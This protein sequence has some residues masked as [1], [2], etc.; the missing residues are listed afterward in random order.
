[1]N[2]KAILFDLVGLLV[3]SEPLW[4]EAKRRTFAPLGI[5]LTASMQS[6][7]TGMRQHDMVDYWYR[8]SP[9][10]GPTVSTVARTVI[11][12]MRN[13]IDEEGVVLM[14]GA[15]EAL[16]FTRGAGFV[17]AVVSSS[18]FE[19]I[20][21]V[22]IKADL[23][24]AVPSFFSAED[25]EHGKPHPAVY[26]R[27]AG[28]LGVDPQ[29]CVAVE[30]SVHGVISGKAATMSVVAVPLSAE[31]EDRRFGVADRVISSLHSLPKAV[32]GLQ[33]N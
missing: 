23:L 11:A 8:A 15:R 26:L 25:D 13:V 9:W 4:D 7:T 20:E 30:D 12:E 5:E 14:D 10:I 32:E 29:A 28:S 24:E 21:T 6:Q 19:V 1:M 27:A 33:G 2:P 16:T 18:P 17:T 31:L 3:D 22:L